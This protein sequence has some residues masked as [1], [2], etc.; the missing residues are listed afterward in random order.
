MHVT[1]MHIENLSKS[2]VIHKKLNTSK[3]DTTLVPLDSL[4]RFPM[5][6]CMYNLVAKKLF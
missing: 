1:E 2:H 5:N 4:L 6:N 3:F